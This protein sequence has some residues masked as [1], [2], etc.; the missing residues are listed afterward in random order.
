V[1]LL[2]ADKALR[3][4]FITRGKQ[5]VAAEFSEAAVVAQWK[6]LFADYE[7]L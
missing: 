2:L 7:A 4:E 6:T 3:R 5:R 1:K